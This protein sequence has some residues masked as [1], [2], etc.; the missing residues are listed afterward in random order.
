MSMS[1]IFLAIR[2]KNSG[3]SMVPS[4]PNARSLLPFVRLSYAH[5]SNYCWFDEQ[6]VQHTVYQAEGGEQ[7]DPMMPLLF[8]VGIQGAL[9]EVAASLLPG[10]E[11]CAFL[12]DVYVVC[13]PDRVKVLFDLLSEVLLRTAGI[14]L[15]QGKTR[16][17]NRA[18]IPLG[19]VN[20]I[21][22]EEWQAE[23]ITVLGTPTGMDRYISAKM[24]E[25]ISKEQELW[26]AIPSVPH[27]QSAWQILL[28]SANPRCNHTIRTMPPT[29]CAAYCRSHDEGIWET[30]KVLLDGLPQGNAVAQQLAALPM[31]MGGL[32]LRS[33][34]RCAPAAYW[35]SW[36][37]ALH[38]IRQRTPRVAAMVLRSLSQEE[39]PLGGCLAELHAATGQLDREGFWWRPSW[40]EVFEGKR[41][42]ANESRDP[43]EW[44]HG[45]QYWASSV[46]DASFRKNSMLTNQ[47][48]S[49]QAH[50]RSHSGRNAGVALS[51]SPTAAEYTIRPHLFRVL[52]L[53]R[54]QLP[55]PITE[56]TCSGC[57]EP[58]DI[59]GRHRAACPTTGLLKKRATPTESVMAR[60]CREAG[61]R[62][63]FNAFLRDMHVGVPVEDERRIEVLA[64]DLPCFNGAQLAIDVTLRSVLG[65]T[66]EAQPQAADVDGAVLLQARRDKE[67]TYPELLHSRRCRLVVVAI[68]TGGRWSD[69]GA[70]LVWQLALARSREVPSSMSH[71]AALA[72]ERRWTRMLGTAC[73]VSFAASLV[74]PA[75]RATW[76]PTDGDTPSLAEVFAQDP[77]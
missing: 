33:A 43:G 39:E 44:P 6:G 77:R 23:G 46:L 75:D 15:H 7:G 57:R 22:P 35:A 42:P 66:G 69:E 58:L 21:G 11:L 76:S 30:A 41:P 55:L 34:A 62:V 47:T 8:A 12:D 73:A 24:D 5:P 9:Q 54:L 49:R 10:E 67:R 36:A 25:R 4:M 28:Q 65:R 19:N 61:A 16:A 1:F 59:L 20:D 31:R 50:L 48:A 52:L 26:Q 27:L 63:K 38:M 56:K 29:L 2:T 3:K 71:R 68:E 37:D 64:Q 53:Q 70:E 45:W 17:W 60:I 51:H 14:E 18:G 13:Q 72:F 32:G 40:A 74:E